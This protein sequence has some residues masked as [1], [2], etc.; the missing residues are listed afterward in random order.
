MLRSYRGL[1]VLAAAAAVTFAACSDVAPTSAPDAAAPETTVPSSGA[2]Y[3]VV[4]KSSGS[5][6]LGK[7]SS[8]AKTHGIVTDQVYSNALNGFAAQLTDEKAA[9]L[10]NDPNVE[11]VEPNYPVAACSTSAF[12]SLPWGINY[13]DGDVSSTVA[14][15]GSGAVYGARVY[16]VD[17][18][19]Y[20]HSDLNVAGG[21]NF[22]PGMVS[23]AWQDQH[24]HGT[25]VAG[26][27]GARDNGSYVVGVAP[28][29]PI[30]SLRVLD[31][32]GSG[33]DAIVVSALDWLTQQVRSQKAAGT[34]LPTVVNMSLGGPASSSLD[35]AVRTLIKEGVVVVAAAGN[36]NV[37]ASSS[38]P[39][40]VSEAITVGAID[41]YGRKASFSNYGSVVD[42]QAPG[43]SVLS[44]YLNGG[45][46]WMSGTSMAAPHVTGA[47][48]LYLSHNRTKTPQQ[49]RDRLVY[50]ARANVSGEPTGTTNRSLYIG[51]RT[52]YPS[53]NIY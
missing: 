26:T 20:P 35:Y 29:V 8:L 21:R 7:A 48:A 2:N 31:A 13:I 6:G 25:H 5:A 18:G 52:G 10:R 49:V 12:Q 33:N 47:A 50:D 39:A 22:V 34:Y 27:I 42:L 19:V 1:F 17:S 9:E 45:T 38:S 14:G 15:N 30:Y 36:S 43:V 32:T 37:D 41:Y 4:L 11:L 40:R 51:G 3:I 24:G 23:S 46:A 44:T 53:M 16:I 28:G